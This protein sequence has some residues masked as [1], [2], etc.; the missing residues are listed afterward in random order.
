MEHFTGGCLCGNVRFYRCQAGD[1]RTGCQDS[2]VDRP[3]VPATGLRRREQGGPPRA[4]S[5]YGL[6]ISIC[7]GRRHRHTLS[8]GLAPCLRGSS[9][10]V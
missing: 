4:F 3:S 6:R 9:I 1:D 2:T 7:G 5:S 8:P 10:L